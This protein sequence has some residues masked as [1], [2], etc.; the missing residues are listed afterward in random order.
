M[1]NLGAR[2]S[3]QFS[4]NSD[5]RGL[6]SGNLDTYRYFIG[7]VDILLRKLYDKYVEYTRPLPAFPVNE[8]HSLA[9]EQG[10]SHDVESFL[11][12]FMDFYKAELDSEGINITN[13]TPDYQISYAPQRYESFPTTDYAMFKELIVIMHYSMR[14]HMSA[15]RYSLSSQGVDV[16]HKSL[17]SN[18]Q[19]IEEFIENVNHMKDG[20]TK[21]IVKFPEHIAHLV[22]L[23]EHYSKKLL[24][25]WNDY[26]EQ[27]Y[28]LD[29][30][31]EF[32]E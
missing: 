28:E 12:G 1:K 22:D 3:N 8:L 25:M 26:L 2:I 18:Q 27:I 32:D 7:S 10:Y 4:S 9:A 30:L 17:T 23:H 31:N 13:I 19:D 21:A 16:L 5:V 29:E 20:L 14:K 6:A 11:E 24:P 15:F